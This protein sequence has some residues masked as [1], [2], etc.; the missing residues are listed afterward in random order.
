[1]FISV[2]PLD[3]QLSRGGRLESHFCA[4]PKTRTWISNAICC[5]CSFLCS[6]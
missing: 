2:L 5:Y 3:I 4:C 1:L 6:L